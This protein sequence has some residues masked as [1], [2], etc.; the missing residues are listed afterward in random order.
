MNV[1]RWRPPLVWAGVIIFLT[2]I[3]NPPVPRALAASDKLAHFGMYFGFG[4]L[5]ARAVL[6]EASPMFTILATVAVGAIIGAVDEWHQQFIPGRSMDSADW[7][8]DAVG[9]AMGVIVAVA[10]DAAAR[11]RTIVKPPAKL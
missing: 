7:R 3:P 1:R 2:S 5:L 6:Q 11:R 4:F 10:V 8:A 9:V